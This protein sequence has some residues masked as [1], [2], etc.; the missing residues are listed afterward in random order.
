MPTMASTM[1]SSRLRP[2]QVSRKR[3]RLCL[4]SL[5]ARF[6]SSVSRGGRARGAA[7]ALAAPVVDHDGNVR[8]QVGQDVDAPVEQPIAELQALLASRPFSK[9]QTMPDRPS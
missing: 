5:S 4:M 6:T 3:P 2:T 8:R 1:P 9:V 7:H